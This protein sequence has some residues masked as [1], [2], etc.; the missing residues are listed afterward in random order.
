[1]TVTQKPA[2]IGALPGENLK[3]VTQ[4]RRGQVPNRKILAIALGK[5]VFPTAF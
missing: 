3:P 5:S 4:T 1:V 2:R